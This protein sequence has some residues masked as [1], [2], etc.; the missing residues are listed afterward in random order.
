MIDTSV[1]EKYLSGRSLTSLSKELGITTNSLKKELISNGVKIRN[2]NEQ[3]KFNPQNQRKY[4]V[5]DLYFSKQSNNMAYLL[6]FYAADGCVYKDTNK[7]KLTLASVDKPFLETIRKELSSNYPIRDYETKEG[8]FCSEFIFSS[9]QIKKDFA[10]YNIIPLKTYNFKFPDKLKKE[11]Y[12]DFIRG[13]FD[14]DGTVGMTG[15]ALRW[16]ICSHEKNV[17]EKIINYFSELEIPKV[18]I[19]KELNRNLYVIQYSTSSTKKIF[20]ILYYENCL[21]LPRKFEKYQSLM[22]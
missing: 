12:I 9:F 13:Y 8:Y 3:N 1:V 5:N 17:L 14:G 10:N 7:I 21:C 4:F 15:K 20:D 11:Y 16:Q 19:Q 6:G 22:K 18:S 2:R